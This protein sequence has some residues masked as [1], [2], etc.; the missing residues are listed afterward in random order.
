MF[1]ELWSFD[2]LLDRTEILVDF[3]K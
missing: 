1:D 3:F 2:N